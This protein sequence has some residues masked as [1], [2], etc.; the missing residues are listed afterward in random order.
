MLWVS[1]PSYSG[2]VLIR[3]RQLNGRNGVGFGLDL[4]PFAELQFPPGTRAGAPPTVNGSALAVDHSPTF[5]GLLRT[6]SR[7]HRLLRSHRHR[8]RRA[9]RWRLIDDAPGARCVARPWEVQQ[10]A[11]GRVAEAGAMFW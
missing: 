7:R 2:P 10:H 8:R 5:S 1:R 6:P 11:V 4:V 3:G 9:K